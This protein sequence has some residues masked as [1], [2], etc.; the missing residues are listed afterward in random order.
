MVV[1]LAGIAECSWAHGARVGCQDKVILAV[2]RTV[3]YLQ[4][5]DER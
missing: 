5:T 3:C 1:K 2:L 4:W